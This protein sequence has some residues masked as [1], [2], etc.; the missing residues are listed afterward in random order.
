[1]NYLAK[2]NDEWVPLQARVFSRW[3]SEHLKQFPQTK[4]EDIT[5]DLSSGV[6]LVELAE[7]LT[8]KKA[9]HKWVE[10]PKMNVQKVEN[11]DLALNMFQ[12]DGVKLVGMSGKDISDNNQKLI[13]GLIWTL[14]L[15][16]SIGGSVNYGQSITNKSNNQESV[17][18]NDSTAQKELLSWAIEKTDSYANVKSFKPY[19]LAMCAL[20]DS[21]CPDKIKYSTLNYEDH[22]HNSQLATNVMRDLGISCYIYPDDLSKNDNQVDRKTLLTQLAAAKTVLSKVEVN[23]TERKKEEEEARL[24]AE[25]EARAKA[26]EEA[27]L[28]AEAESRAKAEEEARLKAEEARRK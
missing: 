24:K 20:L 21:Y 25:S 3:V 9:T 2:V 10:S 22:Q 16:Y 19:D 8:H 26:K 15:H 23:E 6:A 11:C 27:R 18:K 7:V 5:K 4:V 14:I 28:K 12:N 13:L 17:S 1:M